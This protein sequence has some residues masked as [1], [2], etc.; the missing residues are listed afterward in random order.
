L[1]SDTPESIRRDIS[2]I[3]RELPLDIVE[4]VILTPLPGCEDHKVLWR[5]GVDM[6][7]DL[8]KYDL[9]HV[10]ADHP[11]MTRAEWQAVY[12][13][14]WSLYYSRAHVETLLRRAAASGIPMMS[15]VKVL[16]PFITMVPLE[17]VHP[18]QAG[19]F[20]LKHPDERR[21]ELP[22]EPALAFYPRFAWNFVVKHVKLIGI[23]WWILAIK[24]RIERD[25][26][27]LAYT[28]RALTPVHDDDGEATLDLL[29][30]TSGV[31]E[32]LDHQKKVAQLTGAAVA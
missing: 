12:N 32:A 14:A 17:N 30:K 21:P 5:K 9:E 15:F 23:V 11:N 24:W 20:R 3:Q 16:V 22:R 31:R 18:L 10:V 2:I 4:F 19:L 7:P 29:T 26:N 28:D 1:P 8:N 25:P 6:D 27:R 13:E